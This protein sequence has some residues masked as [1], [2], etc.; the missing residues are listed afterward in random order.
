[1]QVAAQREHR[2]HLL[3]YVYVCMPFILLFICGPGTGCH[4]FLSIACVFTFEFSSTIWC[5]HCERVQD[6]Y[7]NRQTWLNPPSSFEAILYFSSFLRFSFSIDFIFVKRVTIPLCNNGCCPWC[8]PCRLDIVC[9][10]AL[11][12]FK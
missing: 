2:D 11:F 4:L 1:M 3:L 6:E 10:I 9:A 5:V 12:V 7:K 8:P